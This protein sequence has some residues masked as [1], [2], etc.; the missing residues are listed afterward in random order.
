MNLIKNIKNFLFPF[1]KEKE[2]K[3]IF[4]ILNPDNKRNSMLVGGCVR[5][6]LNKENII[7]IDI[8]TIFT[9][10]QIISKFSKSSFK[11]I[12]S[13]IE[14]GTV[15]LSKNGKNFE[16]TTL[17]EDV[18]TD[19]RHAKVSFT[20][21]WKLDS[22]RRDFTINAIY[23]DEKGKIYDPQNGTHDLKQK[24]IKFIGDP[25]KRIEEDYLRIL[26]FL[27]FIL[28]YKDYNQ[29]NTTFKI[30]KK[31][32]NGIIKLSKER[33][34]SELNKIIILENIKDIANN[35]ELS[36]IFKIIFPEFRYLNRLTKINKEVQNK[37]IRSE[38]DFL[39][40]L[41]V[42]D[43]TDNHIY[44]SHKYKVSNNLKQY[45]TFLH[46]YSKEVKK[47]KKYFMDDL[48]KNIF[49]HGKNKIASLAKFHFISSDRKNYENLYNILKKI[50]KI[51][52]PKFPITGNHLLKKGIKSGKRVGDILKK[53]EKLWVENDFNL[54]DEDLEN[55]LKKYV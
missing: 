30:I 54:K 7:D 42:V 33:I 48:K 29:N 23:L 27:R 47:N 18:S 36:E 25:Q 39:L 37:F 6:Y 38:K 45:L 10:E 43:D 46:N 3:E 1:Y 21:D 40:A 41:L 9:P 52:I 5:N 17:R 50:N 2:I 26:R 31:N 24:K 13:G 55:L 22:E 15:T 35:T 32:V 19:G 4:E 8:A 20:K 49:Y 44:F 16:I 11:I 12:K 28:K 14:H 51:S 53:I 34:L